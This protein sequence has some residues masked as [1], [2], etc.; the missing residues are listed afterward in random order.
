MLLKSRT[1]GPRA[2][3]IDLPSIP[4]GTIW[5]RMGF[6]MRSGLAYR[7][8]Y[9]DVEKI[10]R[11]VHGD[12][13]AHMAR[14]RQERVA[15]Y[16]KKRKAV[17]VA[18]KTRY[19]TDNLQAVLEGTDLWKYHHKA[20]ANVD[21]RSKEGDDIPF[22]DCIHHTDYGDYDDIHSRVCAVEPCEDCQDERF[23]RYLPW[24]R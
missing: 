17:W 4:Y 9:S 16:H 21:R 12:V 3:H 24:L 2:K 13:D 18:L 6:G 22:H 10:A 5:T 7:F 11:L 20:L 23:L 14:K 15:R 1:P 8:N 19:H